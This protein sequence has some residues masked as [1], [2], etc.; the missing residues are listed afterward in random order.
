MRFFGY[1]IKKGPEKD[2]HTAGFTLVEVMFAS[3][4]MLMIFGSIFVGMQLMMEIITHSKAEAGAR[5]LARE[6]I[7]YIRSL[8][9][10]A[11]GTI[12]GIPSGP[13]PQNA[14]TSL[15]NISYDIRILIQFLD[16]L[17]DGFGVADGNTITEDSKIIKI[18]YTWTI[19]G[20]TRSYTLVSDIVPNGIESTTGGGTLFINVFDADVQPVEDAQ[21]H[22]YNDTGSTTIDITVNTDANGLANFP[23]APAG[24]GYQVTVTKPGY[25]TDQTYSAS[26]TNTNPNP[27]HV[28]VVAGVVSTVYMFIDELSDLTI[29]SISTPVTGLFSDSFAAATQLNTQSSTTV[30]GGSLR[31]T[32]IAGSYDQLGSALAVAT[33][34]TTLTKWE[35]LDFNGTTTAQSVFKVQL[36]EVSGTGSSSVYTL[37]SDTDLPGN[38]D[39]FTEGP[40]DLT[41]LDVGT[42]DSIAPGV[43]F[44][45]SSTSQ[46]P[47]LYD[48]SLSHVEAENPVSGVTLDL[49]STKTIGDNAGVPVYKYTNTVT[50][51]GSGEVTLADM[52]WDAYDVIL[53]GAVEGYD[54][55]ETY[56]PIPF[57]LNP[58]VNDT[59]TFVL[60]PHSAYSLRTTVVDT[61]G[62][63]VGGA[64]VRLYNGGFDQTDETSIYGQTFFSTGVASATDYTLEVSKNGYTT[65]VQTNVT[66]NGN[67]E[68]TVV[69]GTG[70][71]GETGTTTPPAPSDYLAGYDKRLPLT[72]AGTTLF[73]DVTNFPVYLDL[74]DLPSSFFNDVQSDGDDI[75][76]TTDDGQTEVPYELVSIN[77]GG[78]TGELHF[79]APSLLTSTTSLF[80]VYYG[81][82][83]APGYAVGDT[84]GRNNVWT[85]NY[86][87]VYHLEEVAA[88][89][90]NAN[91]YTDATG[92]GGDGDDNVDA[93]G[94]LGKLGLGQ[95]LNNAYT[96][97]IELPH[98]ILHGR[99]DVTASFWYRTNTNDY[100]S[101]LSGARNNT[102]DGAN[103]YLLWF[104]DYN[105][106]QFFS[107]GEPRVN[108]DI[109][110]INDN[111]WR[112]YVSVRDDTNNQTRLYINASEDNQSPALDSMSTLSIAS[113][114]L[115]VG[116]DQDSVGGGFDQAL[117]GEL[118]ELRLSNG[119][120]SADWISNV[121]LN[122]NSPTGFYTIGSVETE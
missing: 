65:D 67:V 16:R 49:I 52:E 122:Q 105:D 13:I 33:A 10:D 7:E 36:F 54:I 94:K 72:I 6:Q 42:Y 114:G 96:D 119:V 40:I 97:N 35:Y 106:I 60:E 86:L 91:L 23:G 69:L 81:S 17:E 87:A 103:E 100:M 83:T 18:T 115:F 31:L 85:N 121:Y 53:D 70:G 19:L 34:P 57:A 46:T 26:A 58:G 4:L 76:I 68:L 61:F 45:S 64:D 14:T 39:G 44:I 101:V 29:R 108:F 79:K 84:Y 90:G 82:S 112:Y 116:V 88:G 51:D 110:S 43:T 104:Q 15:N 59:L 66:I 27:P 74:S 2:R 25:S 117:D 80:Y 71:E 47:E 93:T 75:R 22:I 118:D 56:D 95:E 102:S 77:T 107:H 113:G 9:Y 48:W 5:T 89:S 12:S 99:T 98:T 32:D 30:A 41:G 73:G 55:V 20:E 120:R 111:S 109:A 38:S 21:V 24:G 3:A 78:Q 11:V 92:Q 37:I 8:P 28:A 50:T 62:A 1:T 63:P